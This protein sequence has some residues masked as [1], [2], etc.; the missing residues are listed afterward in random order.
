MSSVTK[1]LACA[2]AL[3]R[4]ASAAITRRVSTTAGRGVR[5][6]RDLEPRLKRYGK[7]LTSLLQPLRHSARTILVAGRRRAR[8]LRKLSPDLI[9]KA[10]DET[11]AQVT[12]I[13][14]TFFGIALT[15]GGRPCLF[16]RE[17]T[18]RGICPYQRGRGDRANGAA[19]CR[20]HFSNSGDLPRA[21]RVW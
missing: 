5:L 8:G 13:E 6:L 17:A 19:A 20:L 9:S 16:D 2:A 12:R 7:S 4:D 14:L 15:A 11:A 21:T 10:M 3:A 18:A 1:R